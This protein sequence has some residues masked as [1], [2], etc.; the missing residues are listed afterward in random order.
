MWW[1]MGGNKNEEK[2]IQMIIKRVESELKNKDY[3]VISVREIRKIFSN[4]RILPSIIWALKKKFIVTKDGG[5]II[6]SK[7]TKKK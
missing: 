5:W 1:L 2:M 4:A 3:T 6:I 7:K